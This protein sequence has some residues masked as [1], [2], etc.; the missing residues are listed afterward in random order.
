MKA[1]LLGLVVFGFGMNLSASVVSQPAD[2]VKETVFIVDSVDY[3]FEFDYTY[4]PTVFLG[5]SYV[6]Y[7]FKANEPSS[8]ETASTMEKQVTACGLFPLPL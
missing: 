3:D 2:T 1:I 8:V 7:T 6:V 4:V 5:A